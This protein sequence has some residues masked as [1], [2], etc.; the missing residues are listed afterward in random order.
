MSVERLSRTRARGAGSSPWS[1]L[2][3]VV[4]G[5]AGIGALAAFSPEAAL[6]AALVATVVLVFIDSPYKT[7]LMV[8]LYWLSFCVYETVISA[9]SITGFF[10]PFYGA[11][12]VGIVAMAV[13]SGIRVHRTLFW[14]LVGYLVVIAMSFVGFL[15]PIDF[16]VIQRVLA[17]LIA[18]LV[19]LQFRSRRG[20]TLVAAAAVFS[21]LVLAVW[22]IISAI[23][24]GFAYRGD[25]SVNENVVAFYVGLGFVV[26]VCYGV[27]AFGAARRLGNAV[28]ML[29]VTGVLAYA[30]LLLAS[31]G[32]V[33]AIGIALVALIA[34]LALQDPRKLL[35][36]LAL[37]AI[38]AGGMLLPGGEGIVQ[39][40]TGERVESGGS[41]T[42]I[43]RAVYDAYRDGNA[44]DLLLG[45]GF[46]SSQAV[47][48]RG[49][50]NLTSTH[51][52]YLEVLYEFGLVGTALF[53]ALHLAPIIVAWRVR[54]ALGLVMYAL[55]FFLLGANIT[56]T[57]PDG[58]LY[59]T[60]L[61]FALAIG[62]WG[63]AVP[64]T[65]PASVAT[66]DRAPA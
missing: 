7:E 18:A 9:V 19:Y 29:L 2:P 16:A 50:G 45:N 4:I 10:Y 48:S 30:L 62:T 41:R 58:F 37:I 32:M 15:E 64:P 46:D 52:A 63:M 3:W 53:L 34:R 20:L 1:L 27:Q 22:V 12:L 47:V 26:A 38:S 23:Q 11:F 49:F 17:C 60:A 56:S 13:G 8:G 6:G 59:W 39:R 14:L 42:P 40:F 51:N 33:I 36:V 66:D 21:S 35:L 25:V 61:A 57:A 43:W 31:R 28:L 5:A 54:G 65:R 55:V 24:G 44:V